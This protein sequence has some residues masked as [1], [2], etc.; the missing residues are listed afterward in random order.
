MKSSDSSQNLTIWSISMLKQSFLMF[1]L[2]IFIESISREEQLSNY[3]RQ[4]Y[5]RAER[6][7]VIRRIAIP[8]ISLTQKSFSTLRWTILEM[9]SADFLWMTI[10]LAVLTRVSYLILWGS[11][12]GT[13]VLI[14]HYLVYLSTIFSN[15]VIYFL[16]KL[17][18][19][20]NL[21]WMSN[22]GSI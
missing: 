1:G 22:S 6:F 21:L 11:M 15:S 9:Y 13:R 5:S 19:L 12:K 4:S 8:E 20:S 18:F 3:P 7:L 10:V 2:F 14:L 16:S 17:Y